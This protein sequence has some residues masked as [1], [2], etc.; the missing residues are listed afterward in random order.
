MNSPR[1]R[2]GI[3]YLLLLVALGAFLYTTLE[4]RPSAN[5]PTVPLA[6]VATMVRTGEAAKLTIKDD[7]I[8]IEERNGTVSQ[9]R[10]ESDIGL[11]ETLGD[12]G[13]TPEQLDFF[14]G[15]PA[16]VV[17]F[18][19]LAVWGAV[20]GSVLLLLRKRLAVPVFLVSFLSM[21]VTTFHNFVLSDGL[22][23]M[24]DPFSLLFSAIIF[25]FAL[26]LYIYAKAMRERGVLT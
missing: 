21:V 5:A 12:L 8:F 17:A 4:R 10:K 19:A 16:W 9:S 13:I 22:S 2:S 25:V 6:D 14:Y 7:R 11:V 20:L 1:V 26:L 3:I 18:W 15:F 23:V 24:G